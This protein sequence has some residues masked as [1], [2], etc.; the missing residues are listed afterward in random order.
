M[1]THQE[2]SNIAKDPKQYMGQWRS[3]AEESEPGYLVR[4]HT[5]GRFG[6]SLQAQAIAASVARHHRALELLQ[7]LI[8]F[9]GRDVSIELLSQALWPDADGD[10]AKNTFNVTLHR[11][12]HFLKFQDVLIVQ[13]GHL[14]MNNKLAWVDAWELEQ[15]INHYRPLFKRARE[16]A[17]ARELA[18]CDK[19]IRLLYQGNFLDREPVHYWTISLRER[20]RSKLLSYL[21]DAGRAWE[22]AG[23]T[24][25]AVRS[26]RRGLE[27][28]PLA[29]ELYQNLIRCYR[30]SGRV[31]E[32]VATMH[33]CKQVLA[34]SLQ[35]L[36]APATNELFATLKD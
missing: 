28:E 6:I 21:I 32:A 31:A 8:A 3:L 15:L 7:A 26:Y 36:P 1:P 9:G 30:D 5:L 35:V 12:R 23:D 25:H 22:T 18:R 11:L 17:M 24:E 27:I 14:S 29:E 19:R 2:D 33:R 13:E 34:D 16:P 4:I 10:A 20:L